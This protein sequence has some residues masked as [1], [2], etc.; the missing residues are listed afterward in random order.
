MG[1]YCLLLLFLSYRTIS[2]HPIH[3]ACAC[4]LHRLWTRQPRCSIF[5]LYG[6]NGTIFRASLWV[7]E[8]SQQDPQNQIPVTVMNNSE[9]PVK[10]FAG[11][12]IGAPSPVKV[13]EEHPGVNTVTVN[14]PPPPTAPKQGPPAVNL[15]SCEV[16]ASEKQE[17]KQLLDKYKDVFTNSDSEVGCTHRSQFRI[18][19]MTQVPVAVKLWRTPSLYILR[20]IS[21]SRTWSSGLSLSFPLLHFFSFCTYFA[22]A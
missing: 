8:W 11:T 3:R 16:T 15:D 6:S 1:L 21:R 20:L 2:F 14:L 9:H 13:E 5:Y 10:L 7:R 18:H 19:T 17:L 22:C 12:R 4:W